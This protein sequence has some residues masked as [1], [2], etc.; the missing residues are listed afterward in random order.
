MICFLESNKSKDSDL[1]ANATTVTVHLWTISG[2]F[3]FSGKVQ[4][5][6]ILLNQ[7]SI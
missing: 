6:L 3:D 5:F 2:L 4:I 1:M 7:G